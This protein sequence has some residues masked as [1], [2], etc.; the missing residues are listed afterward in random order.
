M[1]NAAVAMLVESNKL[2][3]AAAMGV[4]TCTV[5]LPKD[6][7]WAL[8]KGFFSPWI[9]SVESEPRDAPVSR[10]HGALRAAKAEQSHGSSVH[11]ERG[12]LD[13]GKSSAVPREQHDP[14]AAPAC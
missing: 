14:G 5:L 9:L 2:P 4:H 3:C 10:N 13:L 8:L 11:T 7:A 1:C 6:A 12:R